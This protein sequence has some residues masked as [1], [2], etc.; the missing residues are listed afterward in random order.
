MLRASAILQLRYFIVA[1]AH[2]YNSH[3]IKSGMR[4]CNRCADILYGEKAAQRQL[5]IGV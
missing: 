1:S 3:S 2:L 5:S 4:F